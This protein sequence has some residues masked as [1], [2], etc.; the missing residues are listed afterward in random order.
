MRLGKRLFLLS[1]LL[2][3]MCGVGLVFNDANALTDDELIDYSLNEIMFYEKCKVEGSSADCGITVS[4]S[5]IEEKIWTGLTSFMTEEQ[6]AGVMGNMAHEGGFNP[7]RHE[8][9]FLSS[10]PK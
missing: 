7:A 8:G 1:G 3:M 10:N 6:A 4:G 9:K 2:A 5:T